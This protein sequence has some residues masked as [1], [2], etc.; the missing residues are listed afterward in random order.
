MACFLKVQRHIPCSLKKEQQ[1][2]LNYTIF[3]RSIEN[4][5]ERVG[6]NGL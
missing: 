6:K 3:K 1:E 5:K 4:E 2:V